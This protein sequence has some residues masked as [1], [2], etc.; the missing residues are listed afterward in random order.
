M[1][2]LLHRLERDEANRVG[3]AHFLE[4]PADARVA[5]QSPA[6][7]GRA[8]ESGDGDGHRVAAPWRIIGQP[9]CLAKLVQYNYTVTGQFVVPA[10]W[11][12]AMDTTDTFD[13]SKRELI[14]HSDQRMDLYL[15]DAG[16]S[17][18]QK[19]A[20]TWTPSGPET[21]GRSVSWPACWD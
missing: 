20:L 1:R 10:S 16:Y 5:R 4:R 18:I 3:L 13:S 2:G 17:T 7:V 11:G 19:L 21:P 14:E 8:F 6:A 9:G 12:D 15:Q